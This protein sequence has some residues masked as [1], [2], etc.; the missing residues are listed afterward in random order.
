MPERIPVAF[1]PDCPPDTAYLLPQVSVVVYYPIK[2]LAPTVEQ[3]ICAIVNAYLAAA[4]Q[5]Q[6]GVITNQG[7]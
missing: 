3:E 4:E 6:I 1:D 7:G 5:G 2:Q